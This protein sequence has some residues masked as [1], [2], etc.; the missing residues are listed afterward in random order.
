MSALWMVKTDRFPRDAPIVQRLR[1]QATVADRLSQFE[2]VAQTRWQP[3]FARKGVSYPPQKLLFVAL[4]QERQLQV[5]AANFGKPFTF[6]R[7]LPI[8]GLSGKL[9]TKLRYGD[10]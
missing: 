8:Q 1:G 10:F 7:S 5:Y 9:G 2:A 4:K 3:Y 6:I